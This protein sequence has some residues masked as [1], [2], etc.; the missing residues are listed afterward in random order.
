MQHRYYLSVNTLISEHEP[1]KLGEWLKKLGNHEIYPYTDLDYRGLYHTIGGKTDIWLPLA[2]P[3]TYGL[4][5]EELN[6][7][8][9]DENGDPIP[10]PIGSALFCKQETNEISFCPDYFERFQKHYDISFANYEKYG[11]FIRE[12]MKIE[13]SDDILRGKTYTAN[14]EEIDEKIRISRIVTLL[15]ENEETW[16]AFRDLHE[17]LPTL[18]KTPEDCDK[19]LKELEHRNPYRRIEA[20][21]QLFNDAHT[22]E[23]LDTDQ[24]FKSMALCVLEPNIENINQDSLDYLTGIFEDELET[25]K[26][27]FLKDGQGYETPGDGEDPR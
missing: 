9:L 20:L 15:G 14:D 10:K 3:T 11:D 2:R 27:V 8:D 16:K 22:G 26:E 18:C 23:H 17:S 7:M 1:D 4:T 5:D 21:T 13:L 19:Y 6:K 24:I 25:I 12:H